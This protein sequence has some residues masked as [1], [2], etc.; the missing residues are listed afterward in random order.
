MDQSPDPGTPQTYH[1]AY[2][3][4]L[5]SVLLYVVNGLSTGEWASTDTIAPALAIIAMPVV[6]WAVP[7]KRTDEPGS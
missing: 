6:V 1:K 4:A 7:N 5:V 2:A 3:A